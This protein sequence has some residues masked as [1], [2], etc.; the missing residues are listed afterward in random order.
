MPQTNLKVTDG[1]S[2]VS[3]SLLGNDLVDL[4]GQA[5]IVLLALCAAP[6]QI[7]LVLLTLLYNEGQPFL[8][9]LKHLSEGG[10]PSGL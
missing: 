9:L 10:C 5:C 4:L 2:R 1:L 6:V 7:L 3:T 8:D